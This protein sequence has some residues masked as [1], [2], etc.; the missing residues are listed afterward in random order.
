ML[1]GKRTD[2]AEDGLGVAHRAVF[3]VRLRR[4]SPV[5]AMGY[6]STRRGFCGDAEAKKGGNTREYYAPVLLAGRELFI[7]PKK[8]KD[9]RRR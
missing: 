1:K 8:E 3:S 2:R 9:V 5:K 4:D 6:D 7:S